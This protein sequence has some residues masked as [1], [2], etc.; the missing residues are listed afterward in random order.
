MVCGL[1]V[2]ACGLLVALLLAGAIRRFEN[3]VTR[4]HEFLPNT[5]LTVKMRTGWAVDPAKWSA[6]SFVRAAQQLK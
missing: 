5:L 4:M 3:V 2:R 6:A 1:P